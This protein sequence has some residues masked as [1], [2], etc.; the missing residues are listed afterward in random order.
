MILPVLLPVLLLS[1]LVLAE[2]VEFPVKG[3]TINFDVT[4]PVPPDTAFKLL[5]G[6]IQRLVGSSRLRAPEA[7]LYRTPTGRRVL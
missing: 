2:P 6:D 4:L 3:Y 5:T 7:S 1:C